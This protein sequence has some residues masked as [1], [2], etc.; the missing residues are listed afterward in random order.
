MF[1]NRQ[2]VFTA[3]NNQSHSFA[4]ELMSNEELQPAI[5]KRLVTSQ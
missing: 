4:D 2:L 5:Q 3:A 1:S